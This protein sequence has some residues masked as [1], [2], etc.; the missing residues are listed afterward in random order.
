MNLTYRHASGVHGDDGLVKARET[1][2]VLANEFGLVAACAV[3][4]DGHINRT[5]IG[6]DAFVRCAVSVI[7]L[8]VWLVLPMRVAKVVREFPAQ[9]TLN[10]GSF[11]LRKNV[12]KVGLGDLP[13]YELLK[14]LA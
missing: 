4:R 6:E 7:G 1:A 5:A 14:Q 10:D 8:P 11:E 3:T 13:W 9:Y 2:L 12:L